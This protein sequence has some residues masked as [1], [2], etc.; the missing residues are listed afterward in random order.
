[1]M[2]A[3]MNQYVAEEISDTSILGRVDWRDRRGTTALSLIFA[4][5]CFPSPAIW[6]GGGRGRGGFL[7][8]VLPQH[9]QRVL[10]VHKAANQ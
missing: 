5:F 2:R 1:M 4:N 10:R 9:Q 8:H 3:H 6:R 7:S